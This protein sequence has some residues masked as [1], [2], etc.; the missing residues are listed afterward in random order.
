MSYIKDNIEFKLD[1]ELMRKKLE[2]SEGSKIDIKL[3]KLIPI[4]ES[5]AKPKYIFK[6]CKLESITSEEFIVEGLSF[7]SKICADKLKDVEYVYPY[8]VTCGTE[9]A[10]LLTNSDFSIK[11]FIIDKACNLAC[12]TARDNLKYDMNKRFDIKVLTS[13]NPG[14]IIDWSVEDVKKIFELFEGSYSKIGVKVA[15]SG[16]IDPLSSMS[17]FFIKTDKE[18][19]SCEIC[20]KKNCPDREAP[21][22]MDKFIQTQML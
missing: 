3:S 7:K 5:V 19:F 16:M 10:D 8:I 18:F 1:I 6:R 21:F 22:D 11:N 14:S 13:L 17:G 9:I 12:Y 15:D 4:I 20:M 2:I